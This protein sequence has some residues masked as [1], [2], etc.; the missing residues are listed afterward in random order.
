MTQARKQGWLSR[1]TRVFDSPL[2]ALG[3]V[4]GLLGKDAA[5]RG[6]LR[7]A[8]VTL[9]SSGHHDEFRG[10]AF[11]FA[12]IALAA[13]VARAD[14]KATR[15]EFLAFREA[16]PMP[17]NEHEK[18]HRL[19]G[20]ALRDGGTAE[21][22][23][24]RISTLFPVSRHRRLLRD[25]LARLVQV[26]LVDG[27]LKPAEAATLESVGRVFGLRKREVARILRQPDTA[28]DDANPYAILGV[29][30][31]DSAEDIRRSYH[32]LMRENHPDNVLAQGGSQ[33]AVRI[34]SHQVAQLSAAYQ[35]IR[36]ERRD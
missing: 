14:G 27:H 2:H 17:A 1:M 25:V 10:M 3:G 21:Q 19:F 20:M 26:A 4:R 31:E 8:Q 28:R 18:I 15:D 32:R 13:N 34:A 6:Q 36:A 29:R 9:S 11:T 22:H 35:A 33:E 12:V 7:S 24:R 23:A 16:F 5:R 30:P